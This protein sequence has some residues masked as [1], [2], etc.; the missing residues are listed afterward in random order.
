VTDV[1]RAIARIEESRSSHQ[2]WA[3]H[4]DGCSHCQQYGPPEFIQSKDEHLQIVAEYDGV[5]V[6]L[7]EYKEKHP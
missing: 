7:R 4:I 2:R 1:D 3:D 6:I 5:L